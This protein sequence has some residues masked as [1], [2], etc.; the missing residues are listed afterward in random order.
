MVKCRI[1]NA[2]QAEEDVR[3]IQRRHRKQV[4]HKKHH[5]DPDRMIEYVDQNIVGGI[6]QD[7]HR[8]EIGYFNQYQ[9]KDSYDKV[10]KGPGD[11][12][13]EVIPCSVTE[14]QRINLH[15]FSPAKTS[16]DNHDKANEIKM[17]DRVKGS[18]PLEPGC[19]I[20]EPDGDSGMGKFM[21]GKAD[22]DAWQ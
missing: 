8:N 6:I 19:I 2:C 11:G 5:I 14:I 10:H 12:D 7:I 4:K 20:T 15:R 1:L 21:R 16:K 9:K 13:Q 22:K 17:G 3:P 18:S